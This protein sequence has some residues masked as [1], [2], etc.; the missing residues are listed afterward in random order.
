MMLLVDVGNSRIKWV[1]WENDCFTR[2][3]ALFHRELDRETLAERLW[4]DLQRPARVLVANVAGAQMA[5]VL[6]EWIERTWA[7]SVQFVTSEAAS[8][9]VRNAYPNPA[10]MGVDRWVAMIG[11]RA[12]VTQP[13]C[14][15]D[16]GTA[17][18]IDALATDGRH[19]GGVIF[20]G[21]QLM[22]EAL[23]R[24]T[25]QIP[26]ATGEVALFGNSTQ[27][28]V[29]GGVAYAVAAAIDGITSRMES[30]T[31]ETF[32]RLLTG[33]GAETVLPY[34]QNNYQQEPDLLFRGLVTMAG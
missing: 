19:L 24:D 17:I 8:F 16:C 28:C 25:R 14:V 29:S 6:S 9:G 15:V 10:Q 30:T 27:D 31:D 4:G 2:R 11:A 23:Y 22:R 12:R 1:V 7:L 34:L 18:T 33:G 26:A 20:P 5:A 13:C 3:G 32:C 21:A